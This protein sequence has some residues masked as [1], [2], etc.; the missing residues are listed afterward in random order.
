MVVL[1]SLSLV[2]LRIVLKCFCRIWVICFFVWMWWIIKLVGIF[3]LFL[4]FL[5]FLICFCKVYSLF[6]VLKKFWMSVFSVCW[7]GCLFRIFFLVVCLCCDCLRW[8]FFGYLFVYL[9]ILF[10][11][12]VLMK[13]LWIWCYSDLWCCWI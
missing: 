5:S 4:G 12:F 13:V 1:R 9:W 8:F 10:V 3:F 2:F 7:S 11:F 6:L